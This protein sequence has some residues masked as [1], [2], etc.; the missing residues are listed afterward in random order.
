MKRILSY[1]ERAE[2]K[3]A[4]LP[5]STSAGH[6]QVMQFIYFAM[7]QMLAYNHESVIRYL[8]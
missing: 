5:C 1:S 8:F 6:K 4:E 2:T 7:L 3:K